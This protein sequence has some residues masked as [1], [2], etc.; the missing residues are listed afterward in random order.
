MSTGSRALPLLCK[1]TRFL[2]ADVTRLVRECLRV[3]VGKRCPAWIDGLLVQQLQ[4]LGVD[5]EV[6]FTVCAIRHIDPASFHDWTWLGMSSSDEKEEDAQVTVEFT[7]YRHGY[8]WDL[9]GMRGNTLLLHHGWGH[10]DDR[11]GQPS[12]LSCLKQSRRRFARRDTEP[13]GTL[14]VPSSLQEWRSFLSLWLFSEARAPQATLAMWMRPASD[15]GERCTECRKPTAPD[16]K[17]SVRGLDR[18][19]CSQQ[20]A[21]AYTMLSCRI[22]RFEPL[23]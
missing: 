22:C 16:Q 6:T 23:Q 9:K 15:K 17:H 2:P 19:F 11:T 14:E 4:G 8:L 18:A 7:L 1:T 5:A 12:I 13:C 20:C 10:F 3:H 21:E